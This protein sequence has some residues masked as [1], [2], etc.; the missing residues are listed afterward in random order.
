MQQH[1]E[2]EIDQCHEMMSLAGEIQQLLKSDLTVIN[3]FSRPQEI[4]KYQQNKENYY[5]ERSID[6]RLKRLCYMYW[7]QIEAKPI[8]KQINYRIQNKLKYEYMHQPYYIEEKDFEALKDFMNQ[9]Y[10]EFENSRKQ[11]DYDI[12]EKK[13][14]QSNFDKIL[15][16][17][18]FSQLYIYGTNFKL[19]VTRRL[20]F[21]SGNQIKY[22]IVDIQLPHQSSDLNLWIKILFFDPNQQQISRAS[23][24]QEFQKYLDETI[25]LMSMATPCAKCG[26]VYKKQ[27]QRL[28]QAHIFYAIPKWDE[29]NKSF[30]EDKY[31]KENE[32][33]HELYHPSCLFI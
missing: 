21:I 28:I 32:E 19:L 2:V 4:Q 20:I 29:K 30:V 10:K 27:D 9:K 8:H 18:K 5:Y 12:E 1:L 24:I 31:N 11:K 25:N 6:K 33:K 14:L 3:L 17:E 15:E 26:Q 22:Q 16:H 7:Y 23:Y 13:S